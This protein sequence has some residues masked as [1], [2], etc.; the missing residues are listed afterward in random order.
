MNPIDVTIFML[1]SRALIKL[2][3]S[4]AVMLVSSALLS[5]NSNPSNKSGTTQ[6]YSFKIPANHLWTDTGVDLHPGERLHVSGAVTDC[7]TTRPQGKS[8]LLLPSAPAGALLAKVDLAGPPMAASTDI[9]IP[10]I[11]PSHL[12]LGVNGYQCSG[13]IPVKVRVERRK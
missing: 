4:L 5:Q 2:V 13:S 11:N 10:I 12:Y 6:D 7:G 8:H 9:D 1:R 3:L